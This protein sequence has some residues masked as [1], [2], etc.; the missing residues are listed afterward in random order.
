MFS[1]STK[2]SL[3]REQIGPCLL[4]GANFYIISS[5]L[6]CRRRKSVTEIY[7]T[8]W[9]VTDKK[10]ESKCK[11]TYIFFE[12]FHQESFQD[13]YYEICKKRRNPPL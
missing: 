1:D 2:W 4:G 8:L 7:S 12:L 6:E 9:S 11:I 5:V 10:S 3:T 13:M